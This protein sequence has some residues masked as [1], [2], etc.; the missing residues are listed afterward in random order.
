MQGKGLLSMSGHTSYVYSLAVNP[1]NRIV[2]SG[3]HDGSMVI[4]DV[5]SGSKIAKFD[6]H[7]DSVASIDYSIQSGM[8]VTGGH[9]GI[10]RIWD[11]ARPSSCIATLVNKAKTPV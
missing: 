1:L 3:G 8:L 4:F 2:Y 11:G 6:A 7:A 5:T 10:I 9:D